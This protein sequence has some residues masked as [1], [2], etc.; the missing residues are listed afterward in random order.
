MQDS[1]YL[2]AVV[3]AGIFA[4][5]LLRHLF[6]IGTRRSLLGQLETSEARV[7]ELRPALVEA[8]RQRSEL[9]ERLIERERA[10]AELAG[11]SEGDR[12]RV[13]ELQAELEGRTAALDAERELNNELQRDMA[14]LRERLSQERRAA[15]EKLALLEEARAKLSDAFK[16]L[17]SDAL[18]HNNE[19]FLK[20]AHENLKRFQQGA[21]DDLEKRQLAIEELTKPIRESL[22]KVDGT[23][24]ELEKSRVAAYSALDQQLQSL[25]KHHLPQL[26]A[27][28]A[29]LVKALRQPAARG[30]WGEVQ[31]KR[32]VE[33]AGMLEHCDFEEQV[34]Q[35]TENG[36]L[37]P[38]MIV[39]LPGGRRIVVD[40]KA[41]VDAYLNAVEAADEAARDA[42]LTRHAQQ[43]RTHI[44]QLGRKSYFE[45]FEPTPEFV[46]MFVPGEAFFSSALAQDPGLIEYG[47]EQRVIPA[48]PTTLIALLKAI[49]YGWRQEAMARNAVEVAALGKELYER[50]ATLA[51]HWEAVGSRLDQAVDAYNKSVGTLERR[52]LPSA[53]KFRDLKAVAADTEIEPLGPL[54]EET[55]RLTA[56]EFETAA[57]Q[58]EG[59]D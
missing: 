37:R 20:L 55:R 42:A 21:R 15:A 8:E 17:S 9:Q 7:A 11:R 52:V 59:G 22:T 56:A 38:D 4:G 32:V 30:R 47:A 18:K 19:S 39:N 43:V 31:L 1:W 34:S 41:P 29:N 27:E 54:T 50:I 12:R 58:G 45:Q 10:F 28:T 2:T 44:G 51:K 46:V 33:M 23:L 53:R 26:H 13:T 24:G 5:W 36:R 35:D 49:A 25:L 57:G 40:A 14:E 48:S 16:A 6:A 3:A